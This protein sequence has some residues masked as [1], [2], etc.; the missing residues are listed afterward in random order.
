MNPPSSIRDDHRADGVI[1]VMSRGSGAGH[2]SSPI[3]PSAS[4]EE[5][6]DQ[7]A[8]WLADIALEAAS[9]P[10]AAR[11]GRPIVKGLAS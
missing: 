10:D 8:L 6:V 2:R 4:A 1:H 5:V 9:Q 7:L 11:T 3:V